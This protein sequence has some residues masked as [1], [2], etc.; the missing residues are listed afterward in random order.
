MQE[1]G[2]D[3]DHSPSGILPFV[4]GNISL[5]V[6]IIFLYIL[7]EERNNNSFDA[8][9]GKGFL[10]LL[11]SAAVG[12]VSLPGFLIGLFHFVHGRTLFALLGV[13]LNGLALIIIFSFWL[14]PGWI[15]HHFPGH[16]F[17]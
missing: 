3:P 15:F 1:N 7:F 5:L 17:G 16:L 12:L 13:V 8:A 9:I 14:F 11:V 2:S 4:L 10:L 6:L